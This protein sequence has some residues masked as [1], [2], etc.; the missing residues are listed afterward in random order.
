MVMPG[1]CHV[2]EGTPRRRSR[3]FP[4]GTQ[5]TGAFS[6]TI[7]EDPPYT[8][9]S[10]LF[11]G[12]FGDAVKT[13]NTVVQT[14]Y[15]SE[16]HQRGEHPSGY[17][18]CL[19]ILALAHA[20]LGDLDEATTAGHTA[21]GGGRPAWPTMVLAGKLD[22]VLCRDFPNVRQTAAYHARYLET[23]HHPLGYHLPL[24]R[25]SEDRR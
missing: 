3:A 25:S 16:S 7:G 21:L 9:T 2:R 15:Q 17:A 18:R 22:Q 14:A 19:L 23:A 8:A 6:V 12:R 20:G 10:L 5:Q 1:A 4:R 24:P 13:A 11:A